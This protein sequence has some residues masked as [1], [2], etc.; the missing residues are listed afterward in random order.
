MLYVASVS[1][2]LKQVNIPKAEGPDGACVNQ[3]GIVFTD[4]FNFSLTESVM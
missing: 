3:L 2:T 4:I 1:K